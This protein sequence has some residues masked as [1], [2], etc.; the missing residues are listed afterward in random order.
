MILEYNKKLSSCT[1][2]ELILMLQGEGENRQKLVKILDKAYEDCEN[3]AEDPVYP[4][5][6]SQYKQ[7]YLRGIETAE[8]IVKNFYRFDN[9]EV[10]Q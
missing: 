1:K 10:P 7:G 3:D 4:H 5:Y 6:Q 2:Q 9:K 8:N